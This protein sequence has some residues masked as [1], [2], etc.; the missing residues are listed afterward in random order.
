[1]RSSTLTRRNVTPRRP[2]GCAKVD[3]GKGGARS[4]TRTSCARLVAAAPL[5]AW[6]KANVKYST[7]LEKIA[8]LEEDLRE[9]SE[10]LDTSTRLGSAQCEQDLVDLDRQVVDLKNEFGRRTGEAEALK[11]SLKKAEDQLEA[12]ER[13]LGKLGGEKTRWEEQVTT[14]RRRSS[15]V[16]TRDS[17]LAAGFIA[18][19][20]SLP[21]GPEARRAGAVDRASS[22]WRRFDLRRF[23]SSESEMLTWK[24]EGLPGDELSMENAIV[25]L[26]TRRRR[27]SSSIPRRRRASGSR[28]TSRK[29]ESTSLETL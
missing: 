9:L 15:G 3:G 10:S 5:A 24:A 4:S 28:H 17:L 18:H 19:L 14:H 11:L 6:V 29:D 13:L 7:V 23:M 20:P 1:M 8:P 16:C 27:R 2:R 26:Q 25:I 12:A 22:A 21:G